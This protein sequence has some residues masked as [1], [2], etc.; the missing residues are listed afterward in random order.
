MIDKTFTGVN[1]EW[2]MTF[3]NNFL[4]GIRIQ[5]KDMKTSRPKLIIIL[6]ITFYIVFVQEL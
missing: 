3:E 4:W 1:D 5:S 2:E 6:I